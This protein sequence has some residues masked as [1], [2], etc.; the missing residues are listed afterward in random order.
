MNLAEIIRKSS[1]RSP[2]KEAILFR[3]KSI[4]Y[5][6][7]DKQTNRLA[8][9]ITSMG[10]KKGER[11]GLMMSNRP[12]FVT[13]F[14]GILK[15]GVVPVPINAQ[16]KEK[17]LAYVLTNSGASGLITEASYMPIFDNIRNDI[18]DCSRVILAGEMER[19]LEDMSEETVI[20]EVLEDDIAMFMYTS[21]STGNPKGVMLTHNNLYSNAVVASQIISA[22]SY[23]DSVFVV[24]PYFHIYAMNWGMIAP[25]SQGATI[26]IMERFVPEDVF[27]AVKKN[28]ITVF[29]GVPTIYHRL[30]AQPN[31]RKE[32][33]SSVRYA[34][35]GGA[36]LPVTLIEETEKKIGMRIH[37]GYGQT[38]TSPIVTVN[39]F[40]EIRKSGSAGPAAPGVEIKILDD[41]GEE[42]PCG[43]DGEIAVKGPNVM[44]GYYRLDNETERA[45]RNGWFFT[46]DIGRL[47]ED[48]YLYIT[49]RKGDLIISG[50][51]NIYPR[52]VED[53]LAYHPDLVESAVIGVPDKDMGEVIKA[54][55]VVKQGKDLEPEAIFK[56][57]KERTAAFKVPR[58]IEYRDALP[59]DGPGKIIKKLLR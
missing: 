13:A 29:L 44:K 54:F 35:C 45:L 33:F 19:L 5:K 49:D 27:E 22:M 15:A 4:T 59:K 56:F 18:P 57:C 37:E 34:L 40:G 42:M 17:E 38:E 48:G 50:G 6:T 1:I 26:V 23:T 52:E 47:D 53:V 8:N 2:D 58:Y 43:Q 3:N 36:P 25:L 10:L 12:E 41:A 9:L 31:A 30:S 28:R 51:H 11:V 16:F 14:F 39:R 21:G 55:V 32:D 20:A 46:G 24:I 7:L